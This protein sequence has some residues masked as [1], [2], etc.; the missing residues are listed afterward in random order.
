MPAAIDVTLCNVVTTVVM[1][2]YDHGLA[3]GLE[4]LM[5]DMWC[6]SEA[7]SI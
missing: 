6:S 3:V 5:I 2:L 4:L 7:G 1:Y